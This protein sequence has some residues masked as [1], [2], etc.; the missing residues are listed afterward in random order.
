MTARRQSSRSPS[1]EQQAKR[2]IRGKAKAQSLPPPSPRP[3]EKR[4][5]RYRAT[6]PVKLQERLLRANTQRM[7][8]I[9]QLT[10]RDHRHSVITKC[11]FSVLGSTGNVYTVQIQHV[12]CCNC[13]DFQRNQDLCKHVIF[14]LLKV[15]GVSSNSP[16][17]FQKAYITSEL[18]E[19]FEMLNN[20]RVGGGGSNAVMA[21]AQVRANFA[22][23]Q[24]DGNDNDDTTDSAV[25]RRSLDDN[26]EDCDCPVC[27]D[28]MDPKKL[29]LLTYCQAACGFNFHSDCIVKWLQN[30]SANNKSCPNCRQIWVGKEN[31][32]PS[33]TKRAGVWRDCEDAYVNL[34]ELQ[35]VSPVRDTSTYNPYFDSDYKRRR[36]R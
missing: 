29:H 11:D 9:Q 14:V 4:L 19:L 18:H 3:D 32:N 2:T 31:K 28:R 22:A 10:Q 23:L 20:R 1:N 6:C 30:C 27:F 12:P 16:L 24:N 33:K 8:L 36:Y 7:Y 35:G 21:N 17:A 26:N 34:G 5:S 13:P 25:K 15:I